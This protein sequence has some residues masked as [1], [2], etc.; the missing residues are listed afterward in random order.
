LKEINIW[1][2]PS[3]SLG[4]YFIAQNIESH[5]VIHVLM[6]LFKALG[7]VRPALL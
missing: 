2:M 5:P 1:A 7:I 4:K 3:I 6:K